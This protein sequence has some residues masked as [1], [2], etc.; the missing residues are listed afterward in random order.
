MAQHKVVNL[1]KMWKKK[2]SLTCVVLEG[3][4]VDVNVT[5]WSAKIKSY[6]LSLFASTHAQL[7]FYQLVI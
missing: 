3:E 1:L 4:L 5:S 6:R 7:Q 2:V